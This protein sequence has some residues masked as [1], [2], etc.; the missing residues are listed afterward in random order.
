[1]NCAEYK[2][3]LILH[4]RVGA[5]VREDMT[6]LRQTLG[7]EHVLFAPVCRRGL[8]GENDHRLLKQTVQLP[9]AP[10]RLRKVLELARDGVTEFLLNPKDRRH[11]S[12]IG[13]Q[14]PE[15]GTG[16]GSRIG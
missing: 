16:N 3:W 14:I 9:D 5:L 13:G 2:L 4:D 6:A 12:F 8:R 7:D 15:P 1:M 11:L 10:C